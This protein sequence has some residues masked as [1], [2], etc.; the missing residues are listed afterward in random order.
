MILVN[1]WFLERY[2]DRG[3]ALLVTALTMF[4]PLWLWMSRRALSDSFATLC[5]A[6]TIWLFLGLVRQAHSA[7]AQDGLNALHLLSGLAALGCAAAGRRAAQVTCLVFGALY[8]A[9]ALI[10]LGE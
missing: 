10:G 7:R 1:Y 9:L 6:L 8:A 3:R 5:M 2:W 4:S